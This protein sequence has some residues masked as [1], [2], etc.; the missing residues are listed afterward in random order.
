M[1]VIWQKFSELTTQSLYDMLQLRESVFQ[2]EQQC[3]YPDIDN[4]DQY[5]LHLLLYHDSQKL[6][7]YMRLF[8]PDS[9]KGMNEADIDIGQAG[10][11]TN[12]H[13]CRFGRF[14]THQDYR[15]AGI[16][17]KLMQETLAYCKQHYQNLNVSIAAQA[18]LAPFYQRYG[19]V[20]VGEPYDD[21]GV[22]H[23][24]MVLWA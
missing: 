17:K 1:K 9:A 19:F 14:V 4:Q 3:L 2:L 24:D 18:Y 6:I 23:V 22:M 5:A 10:A 15:G 20:T 21:C 11:Y 8:T 12:R 13:V 16:G 7:G